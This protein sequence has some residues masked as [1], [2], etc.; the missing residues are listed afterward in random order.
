MKPD[1][2]LIIDFEATCCDQGSVPREHMEIIEIGAVMA[3]AHDLEIISEFQSFI[4]PVRHPNLTPFCKSLTS[5][6]Q[7]EVDSAPLFHDAILAF[8]K[9]LYQY[10]NF[11]FC[12]WGDYDYKQ[13]EQDCRFNKVP[14][15]VSAQ[16]VNLKKLIAEKQNLMRKPGL[17]EAIRLSG[18]TF[19]G[20]H[21]RGIDDARNIARLLPYIY[22]TETF[23]S[24]DNCRPRTNNRSQ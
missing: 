14:N 12:S 24:K 3:S 13:L 2:Y 17:G 16:H 19:E 4:R 22:G 5:I 10:P 20:K 8:K 23:K 21:H 7:A 6:Q 15:P 1:N 18:L 9:W 11:I